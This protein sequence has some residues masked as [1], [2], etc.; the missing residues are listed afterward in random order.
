MIDLL[1]VSNLA[2]GISAL[3]SLVF[4]SHND[5]PDSASPIV[6][7]SDSVP[8]NRG[9]SSCLFGTAGDKQLIHSR[10]SHAMWSRQ[11]IC[12]N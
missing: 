11:A 1:V 4:F 8:F 5:L 10:L 6:N 12:L 9:S 3:R 2:V 7:I